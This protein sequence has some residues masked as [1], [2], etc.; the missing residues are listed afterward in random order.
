MKYQEIKTKTDKELIT[1]L[2]EQ[3]QKLAKL[4]IDMKTQKVGNV[5]QILAVKKLAARIQTERRAREMSKLEESN[6]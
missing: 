4:A 6:G 2:H 1:L 5:K 3:R